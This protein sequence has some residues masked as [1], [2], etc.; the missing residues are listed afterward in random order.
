MNTSEWLLEVFFI[1]T[2]EVSSLLNSQLSVE[3]WDCKNK[4]KGSSIKALGLF[5]EIQTC[6]FGK[7]ILTF[8][9][10]FIKSWEFLKT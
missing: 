2:I 9:H 7:H 5:F 6:F 3:S 1:Q 8:I 4:P 10:I